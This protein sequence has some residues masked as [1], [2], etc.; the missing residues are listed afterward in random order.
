MKPISQTRKPRNPFVAVA[1][2]RCAGAVATADSSCSA[3]CAA[4]SAANS[5]DRSPAPEQPRHARSAW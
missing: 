4:N 2:A 1:R 5:P 3:N